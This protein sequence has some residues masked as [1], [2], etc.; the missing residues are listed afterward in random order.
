MHVHV[1]VTTDCLCMFLT[2][3]GFY[4]FSV[5][6]PHLFRLLE[7]SCACSS[8]VSV[9]RDVLCMFLTC[10]GFYRVPVHVPHLFQ[11]LQISC[12]CSSPVSVTT[13]S[14]CMFITCFS[15]Y[16]FLGELFLPVPVTRDFLS[17][18]IAYSLPVLVNRVFLLCFICSLI[19]LEIFSCVFLTCSSDS[20]VPLPDHFWCTFRT[21]TV[22][23]YYMLHIP[24]PLQLP[25][26]SC[27]IF[28]THS[29]H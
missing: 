25:N 19:L 10:S 27:W 15:Y 5:H 9:T 20:S 12:A 17:D 13:D 4:R 2:C 24:Y 14:L 21:C 3:F 18:I 8:P 23:E 26:I 11:L 28:L 16:R 22:I 7:M 29:R 1:S 6:A